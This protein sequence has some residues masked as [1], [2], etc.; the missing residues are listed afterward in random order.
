MLIHEQVNV[1]LVKTVNMLTYENA[2]IFLML[3]VRGTVTSLRM[4]A[5]FEKKLI[6]AVILFIF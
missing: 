5:D 3:R 6:K 2:K 1:F 4:D